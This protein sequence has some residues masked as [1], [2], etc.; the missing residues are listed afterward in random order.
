MIIRLTAQR[1]RTICRLHALL[2]LLIEGGTGRGLTVTKAEQLLV[3]VTFDGPVIVERIAVARQLIDEIRVLDDARVEVRKRTAAMIAATA[4][5]SPT[6]HGIGPVTAAII[7]GRVGDIGRF[8]TAGHFARHN[9][10]APIEASSGTEETP[11]AE[12]AR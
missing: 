7:V 8:P 6:I 3:N 12:P 2:C 5:T 9:G 11:P 4:T 10:T 1:T